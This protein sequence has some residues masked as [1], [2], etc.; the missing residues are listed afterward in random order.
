MGDYWIDSDHW[1]DSGRIDNNDS[2]NDGN[3]LM[4]N[5]D[6]AAGDYARVGCSDFDDSD[7]DGLMV[8]GLI[9]CGD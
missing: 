3:G 5:D 8:S 9:I 7:D 1:K 4:V 6:G 2:D